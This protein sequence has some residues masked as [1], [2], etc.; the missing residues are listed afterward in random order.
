MYR[1][2]TG[3][4]GYVVPAIQR[5]MLQEA[6]RL[7]SLHPSVEVARQATYEA[8]LRSNFPMVIEGPENEEVDGF[9]GDLQC[10]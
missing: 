1:L 4:L 8:V 3:K 10:T 9:E 6:A 2:A 7:P 5:T